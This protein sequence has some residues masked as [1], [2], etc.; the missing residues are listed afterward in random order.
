V[1][2]ESWDG[3]VRSIHVIR[4]LSEFADWEERWRT[5]VDGMPEANCFLSYEWLWPWLNAFLG[6][7]EMY[8]VA[9]ED[10][11]N[12][13]GLAP[14]LVDRG[15][16]KIALPVNTHVGRAGLAVRS[17]ASNVI[18]L[19]FKHIKENFRSYTLDIR[20]LDAGNQIT[21]G[22]RKELAELGYIEICAKNLISPLINI[23]E[24][25]DGYLKGLDKHVRTELRRKV[26]KCEASGS[27]SFRKVC[28]VDELDSGFQ[29]FADIERKTRRSSLMK[30]AFPPEDLTGFLKPL[31]RALAQSGMLALYLLYLDGRPIAY[32]YGIIWKRTLHTFMTGFDEG[33]R[34]LSPGTNI[35]HRTLRDA[36]QTKLERVD[37]LGEDYRWKMDYANAMREHI[38]LTFLPKK[39]ANRIRRYLEC[40]VKPQVRSILPWLGTIMREVR[41][42]T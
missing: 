26:K 25:W 8:F 34:Q 27:V 2:G 7:R 40:V 14:F 19:I 1:A 20:K 31:A 9:V 33:L 15:R 39:I 28:G 23:S 41:K 11:E 5:A 10:T 42:K 3:K 22:I 18:G 24:D 16:Q 13:L 30:S 29:D 21:G 4:S 32:T 35:M 38:R 36:F 6:N 17:D 37:F 12:V